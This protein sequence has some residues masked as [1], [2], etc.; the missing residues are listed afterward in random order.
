MQYA[1]G[2]FTEISKYIIIAILCSFALI[3]VVLLFSKNKTVT[4]CLGFIQIIM[5]FVIQAISFCHMTIIGKNEDYIF[6][7]L[8]S[9]ILLIAIL[10]LVHLIYEGGNIVLL[11][12]MCMLLGIGFIMISR[13]DF[14]RAIRQIIIV[15]FSVIISIFIPELIKKL[16]FWRQLSWIY[17]ILGIGALSAVLVLGKHYGGSKIS[18]TIA[19]TITFQP[20]E[21][22]KILFLFFLAGVLW[23]DHSLINIIVSA[24]VAGLHVIIL[25]ISTDLGSALIFF[26]AYVFI[27]FV[28]TRN[29]L[30]LILGFSG[31]SVAAYI[32]YQLFYHV[33]IRV[34]IWQDPWKYID[35]KGYQLTQSLFAVGSGNWFGMGLFGGNPKA[36]PLVDRDFIFSAI[37][38]EMGV[39]SGIAIII[40]CVVCFLCMV[41]IAVKVKDHFYQLIVYGISV[42][43][44]F[45]MFLTIGGGIKF[46]PM[47][48]VTLPFVSYGGSSAMT[49]IFM[50]FIVQG[51]YLLLMEKGDTEDEIQKSA[52]QPVQGRRLRRRDIQSEDDTAY[53][54]RSKSQGRP[55]FPEENF[56]AAENFEEDFE[57]AYFEQPYE[58]HE[59]SANYYDS[60]ESYGYPDEEPGDYNEYYTEDGYESLPDEYE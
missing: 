56:T 8:F 11:N 42:V 45:Q 14:N 35:N 7:Y 29:Y 33:R 24:F 58:Y 17:G 60:Y 50:F 20:S 25:V 54:T 18:Y 15:A 30:Y 40:L 31:G 32:S 39:L 13:L 36:I 19:D 28:C 49:M 47:T 57:E 51:I 23:E 1:F 48:G 59:E 2:Y 55:E 44:I 43:Y 16:H 53:P 5:I 41:E 10:G 3:S 21:F 12:N 37:C 52:R 4:K 34:L 27:V 38:E 46:I 9:Q 26:V 6:L 22:V